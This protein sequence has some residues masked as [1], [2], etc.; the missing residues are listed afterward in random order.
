MVRRGP[1]KNVENSCERQGVDLSTAS[2]SPPGII[3]RAWRPRAGPSAEPAGPVVAVDRSITDP[4][5]LQGKMVAARP[6]GV[7]MIRWLDLTGRH[8]I[9]RPNQASKDHSLIPIELD[10]AVDDPILGQVVWSWSCFN[11]S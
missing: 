4:Q 1:Q 6:E 3:R 7:P 2:R 11:A 9:F 8:L 5:R 10:D